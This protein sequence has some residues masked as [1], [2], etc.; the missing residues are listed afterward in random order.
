MPYKLIAPGKRKNKYWYALITVPGHRTE[1]SL[2]TKDKKQAARRAAQIER[3]VWESRV[4]GG[5]NETVADAIERYIMFRRPRKDDEQHLINIGAMIGDVALAKVAQ[6]HFDECAINLFP[7]ASPQTRNRHVY[8]PLQAALRHSGVNILLR[9][10]KQPKPRH[11]SLTAD[12]RDALI[13]AATDADLKALLTLMFFTGCRISEA[14]SL[15]WD[16]IDLDA[17]SALLDMSKTTREEWVP[18]HPRI[19]SA[20]KALPKKRKCVFRWETKSGPRKPIA[21]LCL[22][23]GIKFNPHMA[24]HTFG[25]LMMENGASLRDLMEAGRWS[26]AKSAMRYTGRKQ[27]RLRARIETL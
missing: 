6:K 24:R 25:D 22:K 8:T 20:F 19:I 12:Q 11:R 1:R 3:D 2:G 4:S 14:I 16:C 17:E 15:T 21:A 13:G 7:S 23:T 9:R 18:L 27:D 26:D 5:S 10:P